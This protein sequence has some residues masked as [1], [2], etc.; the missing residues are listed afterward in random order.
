MSNQQPK[1]QPK[2]TFNV[3]ALMA[4][5]HDGYRQEQVDK[6]KIHQLNCMVEEAHKVRNRLRGQII[7]LENE[8][9]HLQAQRAADQQQ[10]IKI[11]LITLLVMAGLFITAVS[12]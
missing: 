2:P 1:Q 4:N 5:A 12:F 8:L 11:L 6:A 7:D 10:F 3:E 9:T